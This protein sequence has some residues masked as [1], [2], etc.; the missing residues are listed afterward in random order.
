[1]FRSV[2]VLVQ[3]ANQHNSVIK[4]NSTTLVA[5]KLIR[6][7]ETITV[8]PPRAAPQEYMEP[9][10]RR[11]RLVREHPFDIEKESWCYSAVA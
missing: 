1:M 4:P 3:C 5:T 2:R 8:R 6:P 9:P 11:Q 7:G 10:R